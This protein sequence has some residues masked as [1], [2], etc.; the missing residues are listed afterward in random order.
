[1]KILAAHARKTE[2]IAVPE[3]A[4]ALQDRFQAVDVFFVQRIDAPDGQIDAVR[5]DRPQARAQIEHRLRKSAEGHEIFRDDLQ[6]PNW[7]TGLFKLLEM[8][9]PQADAG[10]QDGEGF[11]VGVLHD[12][13]GMALVPFSRRRWE[14]VR[15]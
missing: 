14:K 7:Q 5:D 13:S 3:R 10:A 12:V 6:P 4:G 11:E 2:M 9:F 8:L 1:M 15:M